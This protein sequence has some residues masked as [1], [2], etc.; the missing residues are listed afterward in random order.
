MDG[1]DDARPRAR[2]AWEGRRP[3]RAGVAAAASASHPMLRPLLAA[4]T[5]TAAAARPSR[6]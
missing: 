1:N 5:A 4:L 6:A 3:R 2:R